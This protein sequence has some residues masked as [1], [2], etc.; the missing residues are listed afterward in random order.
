[1]NYNFYIS[2][3]EHLLPREKLIRFGAEALSDVELLAIFLRT[4]YKGKP[5]MML[6][7][8][9]IQQFNGVNQLLE[10]EQKK[11][12]CISG[13]GLAKYTQLKAI[14]EL[15]KRYWRADMK[16]RVI[17]DSADHVKRYLQS[18][19]GHYEQEVFAALFLTAQ[20]HVIE[21]RELFYGSINR[22]EIHPREIIKVALK[23]NAAAVIIAHNHPSGDPKPSQ[24]DCDLTD[25]L[26][27]IFE[28]LDVQ[29]IDHIIIGR[30]KCVSFVESG[31]L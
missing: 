25:H 11:L 12:K 29:L 21:F 16:H 8:E 5:V 15:S 24:A 14:L 18:H 6:A 30:G 9:L 7:Q 26:K 4:G 3:N 10:V 23:L 2:E 20:Y 28:M 1:M 22:A 17:I 27:Q 31:L 13:L 19:M